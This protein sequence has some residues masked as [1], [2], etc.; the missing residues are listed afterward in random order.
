MLKKNIEKI[1]K[2]GTIWSVFLLIGSV[3]LQ[4]FARFFLAQAPSWTE[5]L[6]RLCFIF[7]VAFASPLALK[8]N[9][10]IQLDV[11][12]NMLK[13]TWQQK[14]NLLISIVIFILFLVLTLS[15][16]KFI[17]MG[18]TENSPSMGIKMGVAFSS[19]LILGITMCYFTGLKLLKQLK[20][21]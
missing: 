5:E 18:F 19:M 17:V 11:F 1:L 14:L 10:Y 16:I 9:Y 3:L 21:E 2:L 7:A 4:I 12:Y 13:N 8:S 6:S 20:K 15:S